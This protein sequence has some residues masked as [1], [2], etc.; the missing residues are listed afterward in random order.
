MR[1]RCHMMWWVIMLSVVSVCSLVVAEG[2]DVTALTQ[3]TQR[4]SQ[5]PDEMTLVWWIPEEFWAAS[6]AQTPDMT[7]AQTEE[8]LKVVRPYTMMAVVDG[9]MGAFGGITYKSE[10]YIRTNTRLVDAQGKL[11]PPHKAD[12]VDADTKNMLQMI[13]PMLANMLGPMGQN[14]HFLLFPAKTEEG[15]RIAN[16]KKKG[17]FAVKLGDRQ[18]KW[19]LPLDALL[20]A[21]TCTGCSEQCK[22]SW[23]FCPWCGTKLPEK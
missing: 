1:S 12:Q 9:T 11:Y 4:V 19:R 6:F 15:V 23:N 5:K 20:P 10:E 18:F 7:A 22:G 13:K 2:I 17:R 8:F 21:K 3:E 16:A 14:M